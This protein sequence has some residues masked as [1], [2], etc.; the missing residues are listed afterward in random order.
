MERDIKVNM[1]GN[2]YIRYLKYKKQNSFFSKLKNVKLS[3][4]KEQ[5][6]CFFIFSAMMFAVLV[7]FLYVISIQGTQKE[8]VKPFDDW[9]QAM[10]TMALLDWEDVAKLS[11]LYFAPFLIIC[12][13]LAWVLHGFGFLIIKG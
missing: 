11:Y 6:I 4:N 13:G 5:A 8:E 7:L 12:M 10:P 2:Q 3:K 1:T 9:Y